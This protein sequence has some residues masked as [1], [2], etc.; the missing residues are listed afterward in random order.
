[1]NM[2]K[3]LF[4][5]CEKNRDAKQR[6]AEHLEANSIVL[7][8]MNFNWLDGN[9]TYVVARHRFSTKEA[10]S[11]GEVLAI[12]VDLYD[13]C[14]DR[15]CAEITRLFDVQMLDYIQRKHIHWAARQSED[16]DIE[17]I[18]RVKSLLDE[19]EIPAGSFVMGRRGLDRLMRNVGLEVGE[20][21]KN[22]L[23]GIK[24]LIVSDDM[25]GSD[26]LLV[27]SPEYVGVAQANRPVVSIS[28]QDDTVEW[29]ALLLGGVAV[30][31]PMSIVPSIYMEDEK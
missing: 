14:I 5:L 31:N 22:Y 7:K 10:Y 6:I 17:S 2:Q 11:I 3:A 4:T 8:L 12:D 30:T 16:I 19:H 1:M 26:V 18:V 21:N 24:L 28:I 25:M 15:A 13:R 27:G 23:H 29:K 20:H 9:E